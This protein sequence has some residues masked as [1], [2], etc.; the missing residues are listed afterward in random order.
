[1]R[2]KLIFASYCS[3][4]RHR[5]S[6]YDLL[7]SPFRSHWSNSAPSCTMLNRGPNQPLFSLPFTQ[8]PHSRRRMAVSHS[9]IV[10]FAPCWYLGC[11]L[12]S[13]PY[14]GSNSAGPPPWLATFVAHTGATC[15]QANNIFSLA[16]P[17]P[18]RILCTVARPLPEPLLTLRF[19]SISISRSRSFHILLTAIL[20]ES[21]DLLPVGGS[22]SS[23]SSL[24]ASSSSLSLSSSATSTSA[25]SFSD[26]CWP[27]SSAGRWVTLSVGLWP[28]PVFSPFSSFRPI[29][30]A[31]VRSS[32]RP[33]PLLL[34]RCTRR[35]VSRLFFVLTR[36]RAKPQ[37]LRS[38][39]QILVNRSTANGAG[40]CFCRM[41]NSSI[42]FW[43]SPIEVH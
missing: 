7:L 25:S 12:A 16:L 42:P 3:T 1:M 13:L 24:P 4:S 17:T 8:N 18:P 37:A 28:R 40:H 26:S 6:N 23:L 43:A 41:S 34:P 36:F 15:T 19:A 21:S 11:L 20:K 33:P 9:I 10:L 2:K 29:S 32:R 38:I 14:C 35:V 31:F 27:T 5:L 39:T 22:C 30:Q